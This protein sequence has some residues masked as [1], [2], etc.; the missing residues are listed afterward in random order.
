LDAS[1]VVLVRCSREKSVAVVR[2]SYTGTT[3]RS[4]GLSGIEHLGA[5]FGVPMSY[6]CRRGRVRSNPTTAVLVSAPFDVHQPGLVGENNGLPI[7][8]FSIETLANG[9]PQPTIV[10]NAG[11]VG[12][13]LDPTPGAQ[14]SAVPSSAFST[15]T[16]SPESMPMEPGV[17][18]LT[19][20]ELSLPNCKFP[21]SY[22]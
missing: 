2:V 18:R 6:G 10:I 4:R 8:G 16:P 12:S 13:A 11:P 21:S 22:P 15:G 9:V 20:P 19:I 14:D 1:A 3:G 7:T 17:T 5:P